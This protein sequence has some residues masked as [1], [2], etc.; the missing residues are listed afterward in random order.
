[1]NYLNKTLPYPNQT[2]YSTYEPGYNLD[3]Y[4][5]GCGLRKKRRIPSS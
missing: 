4:E 1:M 5:P 2:F 3:N